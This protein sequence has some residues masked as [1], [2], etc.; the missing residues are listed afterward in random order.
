MSVLVVVAVTLD[1]LLYIHE[2]SNGGVGQEAL[3]PSYPLLI[4]EFVIM[5]RESSLI[6]LGIAN[7]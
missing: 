3:I 1:K 2:S 5:A 4:P 6:G 7:P